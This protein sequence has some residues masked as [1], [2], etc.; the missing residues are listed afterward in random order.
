M[1]VLKKTLRDRNAWVLSRMMTPM[2][3]H[4]ESDRGDVIS[5]KLER[6]WFIDKHESRMLCKDDDRFTYTDGKCIESLEY[7]W[8]PEDNTDFMIHAIKVKQLDDE[9]MELRTIH[10][11]EEEIDLEDFFARRTHA[12]G[13]TTGRVAKNV[14]KPRPPIIEQRV[15]ENAEPDFIPAKRGRK[16]QCQ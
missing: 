5:L 6:H 15:M 1:K 2:F 11:E 3:K 10:E 7:I 8:S 12:G 4:F 14:D 9:T 13:W 16:P